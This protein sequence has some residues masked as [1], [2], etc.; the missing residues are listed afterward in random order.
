MAQA[1]QPAATSRV[2]SRAG[3]RESAKV[4]PP[5]GVPLPSLSW[6]GAG[7]GEIMA[8]RSGGCYHPPNLM[9][10]RAS[11]LRRPAG[12]AVPMHPVTMTH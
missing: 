4:A 11:W 9:P 2:A 7:C 10:V 1:S 12:S 8:V 5:A 3:Q 6:G